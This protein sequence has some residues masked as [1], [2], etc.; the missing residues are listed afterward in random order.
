MD[1]GPPSPSV[2]SPV[3]GRQDSKRRI[4]V[5]RVMEFV[6]GVN[7]R[8]RGTT[9]AA[10]G[11]PLALD[12]QLRRV[13][14][15]V[16]GEATRGT[17]AKDKQ[18]LTMLALHQKQM[19]GIYSIREVMTVIRLF[20]FLDADGSGGV[21]LA[22]LHLHRSFFKKLGRDHLPTVL[23][24]LDLDGNGTITLNEMLRVCF[25]QAND[26]HLQGMLTLAKVGNLKKFLAN[27]NKTD[28]LVDDVRDPR[29]VELAEIFHMF[30]RSGDGQINLVEL[31]EA[32]EIDHEML[33]PMVEGGVSAPRAARAYA[34]GLTKADVERFYQ[35]YDTNHDGLLDF[36][37]FV[38]LMEAAS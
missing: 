35:E 30:D 17:R 16:P 13:S 38:Q 8:P 3:L 28:P 2:L 26:H 36:D 14:L 33:S 34:C 5:T 15:M 6:D 12:K 21:T 4:S 1:S 23:R 29:Q 20:W 18:L 10:N 11:N 19:F 31:L 32:L 25:R 27:R 24:E 7:Q 37:E 22:E 9:T